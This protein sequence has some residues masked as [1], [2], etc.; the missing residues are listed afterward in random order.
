[1]KWINKNINDL[2]DEALVKA[3]TTVD[4]MLQNHTDRANVRADRAKKHNISPGTTFL[5]LQ[6][7]ITEEIA[8]RGL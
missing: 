1:M 2:T 4:V 3:K 6:Q 8:K 5:E 7:E